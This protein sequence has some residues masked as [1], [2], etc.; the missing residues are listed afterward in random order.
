MLATYLAHQ[1]GRVTTNSLAY[2]ALNA[3]RS[4]VALREVS[5]DLSC[6]KV[7]GHPSVCIS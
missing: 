6:W 4:P 1:P 2:S 5:T 7:S 3:L